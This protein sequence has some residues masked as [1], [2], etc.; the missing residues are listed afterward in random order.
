LLATAFGSREPSRGVR[1]APPSRSRAPGIAPSRKRRMIA[2]PLQRKA[3]KNGPA[4]TYFAEF[5]SG[6]PTREQM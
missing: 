6:D 3:E 5:R 1:A 4:W 2:S